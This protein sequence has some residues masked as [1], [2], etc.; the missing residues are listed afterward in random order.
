MPKGKGKGSGK[1][2]GKSRSPSRPPQGQQ[3]IQ[4]F[5][6]TIAC[7]FGHK[8]GHYDDTCWVRY[9]FLKD[10]HL[11]QKGPQPRS[12][13]RSRNFPTATSTPKV[14]P[15]YTPIDEGDNPKKSK[16]QLVTTL[17]LGLGS[18]VNGRDVDTDTDSG[19]S[20]SVVPKSLVHPHNIQR[21]SAL[22]A[23]VATGGISFSLGPTQL[24]VSLGGKSNFHQALVPTTF[25]NPNRALE[26]HRR[27]TKYRIELKKYRKKR[28]VVRGPVGLSFRTGLFRLDLLLRYQLYAN[29]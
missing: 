10:A 19:A 12:S 18:Q 22:P 5:S 24:E 13:S 27:I 21:G 25:A 16:V 7:Q 20:M 14:A 17:A 3:A 2:K 9:P 23:Q 6:A 8:T 26:H 28:G 29:I 15:P 11:K 1:G 4:N